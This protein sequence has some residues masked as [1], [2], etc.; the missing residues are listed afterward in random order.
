MPTKYL[1]ESQKPLKKCT[2]V[3]NP[4][5][6]ELLCYKIDFRDGTESYTEAFDPDDPCPYTN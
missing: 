5:M 6:L 4:Y 1:N 2:S 3:C